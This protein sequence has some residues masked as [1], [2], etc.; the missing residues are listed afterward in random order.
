PNPTEASQLAIDVDRADKLIEGSFGKIALHDVDATEAQNDIVS[1]IAKSGVDSVDR[2]HI[3]V[4][5]SASTASDRD[6]SFEGHRQ[7]GVVA[8]SILLLPKILQEVNVKVANESAFAT[9]CRDVGPL[10]IQR[11][12]EATGTLFPSISFSPV[13][14]RGADSN[15]GRI[16]FGSVMSEHR[17]PTAFSAF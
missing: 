2:H 17:D 9:L 12:D 13:V 16:G 4:F 6:H 15:D 8:P 5:A 7:T 10:R 11:T 14:A 1:C 3:G